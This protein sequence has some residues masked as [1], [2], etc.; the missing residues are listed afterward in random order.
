M[1]FET[2]RIHFFFSECFRFVVIQQPRPKDEVGHLEI[3]LPWQR[4]VTTSPLYWPGDQS[5]SERANVFEYRIIIFIV[6]ILKE[7]RSYTRA[8]VTLLG[9]GGL[10]LC[11]LTT[12]DMFV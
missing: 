11:L 5:Q 7:K 8:G 4:D 6:F 2:V 9:G 3:L 1:K 10:V 12:G